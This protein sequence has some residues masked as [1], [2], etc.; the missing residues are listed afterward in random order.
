MNA[1][2]KKTDNA[3]I[4]KQE[5]QGNTNNKTASV[6]KSTVAMSVATLSSRVTGLLRTWMM[7]FALGNTVITS[8]YNVANNMPNVIFDLVAGGMLGAAFIPIFMLEKERH[9]K[10]GGNKFACN[11]LNIT[12][13]LMGIL[14]IVATIF[15]PEVIA[16]QT[17]T[18]EKT[19]TVTSTAV[20]FFRLF[21]FQVLFYGISAVLTGI[22]NGERVYFMPAFAPAVN[23]IVVIITFI[24]YFVMNATGCDQ[25][26]GLI[27]LGIGT[28][29]GVAVQAIMQ[30]PSLIK[31][32]FKWKPIL[33]LKDPALWEGIKIAI[34]TFIFVIGTLVAFS[35]RNAFSLKIAENG[36]ATILYAWIWFQLPHG[37]IAVSL[38]RTMFTEMSDSAA[39][40]DNIALR[41][42]VSM[43]LSSTLMLIIPLAVLMGTFAVPLMSL[44]RAGQFNAQ[45]VHTVAYVL[46]FWV[47]SLPFY[48]AV[49]YIYNVYAAIR[50]FYLYA[51]ISLIFVFGQCYLYSALCTP[52][53]FGLLGIPIADFAFYFVCCVV[54]IVVIQ[55]LIGNI[56]ILA[57]TWR[58]IRTLV[59][60]LIGAAAG[61]VIMSL[62]YVEQTSMVTGIVQLC[63][64]GGVSLIIIIALCWLFKIPE[65]RSVVTAVI[66]KLKRK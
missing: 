33:D 9:G 23:N 55:K 61:F 56:S 48:S 6:A 31:T 19:A 65:I 29:L 15:A 52:G 36:P 49:M 53:T 54:L 41:R 3:D 17:F 10:K 64:C 45:D 47:V 25:M 46:Q 35:C 60:S 11:I 34:P 7:A 37:V 44:F 58:A 27:V 62:M 18:V 38:S 39:K 32:G 59:A 5:S 50:K 30:I 51:I 26:L 28:T 13:I 2:D 43:G 14:S 24:I 21:A 8:A 22:L 1:K 20:M 57:I 12:I 4:L 16:T 63:L 66:N 42:Q 40:G